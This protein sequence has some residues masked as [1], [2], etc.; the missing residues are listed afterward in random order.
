MRPSTTARRFAEAAFDVAREDGQVEHWSRQLAAASQALQSDAARTFFEDPNI[1]D[2]DKL[3]LL[4]S[5]FPS[6]ESHLLNLLR[7]LTVRHRIH[8]LPQIQSEFQHLER[9]ARGILEAGV[10]VARPISDGEKQAIAHRLGQATGRE[11]DITTRIDPGIIGGI[12]I[13][14]GDHLIDASVAGRLERL[15]QDLAV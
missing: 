4:P 14:V 2:D 6:A 8:L 15:R 13:R 10:T 12:I 11:V 9:E 7:L 1:P 5:L 3:K